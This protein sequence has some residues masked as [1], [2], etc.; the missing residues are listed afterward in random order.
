M[1][2][3]H[4]PIRLCI[5][6][7]A[8][9]KD[10]HRQLPISFLQHLPLGSGHHYCSSLSRIR[11]PNEC[12]GRTSE[13]T[14]C[15]IFDPTL[16]V[17]PAVASVHASFRV[18]PFVLFSGNSNSIHVFCESYKPTSTQIDTQRRLILRITISLIITSPLQ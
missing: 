8:T 18:S 2:P 16:H 5:S 6:L 17:Y 1:A 13:G 9:F 4:P 7:Y 14:Y 12:H 3:F 11:A 10:R 15:I